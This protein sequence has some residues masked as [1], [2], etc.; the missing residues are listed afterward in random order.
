MSDEEL[1]DYA[2]TVQTEKTKNTDVI[3]S[4]PELLLKDELIKAIRDANLEHPSA[5]Q[6]QVIP[7]A[8]LGADILCQA[9]SGT[10]K[11]V[12]FVL[13][14]L[15]RISREEGEV[16]DT[17]ARVQVV[18]IAN[19]KEMVV[20]IANEFKRFMCYTDLNVEMVFGGVDVN[21]DIEKL[22]GRVDVVV[23]TPGRLFD[24]IVRGA[25]DVSQLRILIIDEVDSILSSLSSRWTVQRIIYKTPVGKQTMLFTATLSDEMRNTC[26]LMVRNPFVLQVDEERK[27]TLHGL[28]QGYVNVA[29][30]SKRDKLIGLIDGIRDISQCVIFCRDKRRV[31]VLA[32]HLKTKGLPA[33]S[34]T[35]D[36]D[37]NERMQ[38]FMS[39]K[40]L[41]YRFLVTTNL[42]A[43]GIDIAEINLVVNYDMAED[44]QTYLHRVGRAGRFE[45]RGT[46]VS[47]ICNEEDIVV[48]NEVQERFE[49]SIK[50][51]K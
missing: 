20:Q 51:I 44:A 36:Y 34:I 7:K 49:V 46:A 27:L 45:T 1:I 6:Q 30:D 17:C 47:F 5:V 14:A 11:T 12:V 19:T 50:E 28:E 16:H 38:R 4:F 29:E 39:F 18:A 10:G 8:V 13:S 43:R 23:G 25:L 41:D 40:N 26:L 33:V 37:T 15:Q 3:S 42:M 24:L 2:E 48:L 9:K 31:E 21:G 32:E 22:K 35:S